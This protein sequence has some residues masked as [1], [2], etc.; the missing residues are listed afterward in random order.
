M[1]NFDSTNLSF[2][3]QD[4][5]FGYLIGI[6]GISLWFLWLIQILTPILILYSYKSIKEEM[7]KIY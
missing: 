2:Q 6:D 3:Y 5:L 7:I 1:N 4:I